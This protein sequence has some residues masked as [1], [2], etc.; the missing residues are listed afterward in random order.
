MMKFVKP[1]L[2][3]GVPLLI[4]AAA[5]SDPSSKS[6]GAG[7]QAANTQGGSP[8]VVAQLAPTPTAADV[9]STETPVDGNIR[10]D[11]PDPAIVQSAS[12]LAVPID[13]ADW[14]AAPVTAEARK[15]ALLRAEVL[16]ARAKFSPGVIDGQDGDNLKNAVSAFEMAHQLPVDGKM[17]PAVWTALSKDAQPALTDYTITADDVKGPFLAKVPTGMADMA[18]LPAMSFTGPVQELA[19]RFH[20]DEAL[21]KGL[22]PTADFGTAGTKIVVAALG[23]DKLKVPVD[24]IEV[25]KTKRQVRAYG[26]ADLLLAVYPATVGSTDRPAPD[27]EWAVRTVAPNPTYTYDPSRLTF[28]KASNGKLTI[29]AGPN[30]PVGSTWIDLTKD[31]YGIHGTPDPRM[32]GKAAS[33]GCVR[34]TNWDVRQLSLAV[35]KG[36]KV[37]FVG[38]E[39]GS[40]RKAAD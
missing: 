18:K 11:T 4:L 34:L 28:G 38:V 1:A 29:P 17:S 24:R 31:T 14:K 33:H 9:T 12:Q 39:H 10:P 35:K 2:L 40:A 6:Q 16:L 20:M 5:C 36:T 13:T 32:V 26:P 21:L 25:D 22:N 8:M 37:D 23:S 7:A 3:A 27:G 15:N 30:N 19:E